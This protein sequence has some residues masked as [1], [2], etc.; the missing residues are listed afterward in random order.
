MIGLVSADQCLGA[1]IPRNL[2]TLRGLTIVASDTK[3]KLHMLHRPSACGCA[4]TQHGILAT[5]VPYHM[6]GKTTNQGNLMSG[7]GGGGVKVGERHGR[8]G[9]KMPE[10]C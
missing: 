1:I 5:H 7:G 3:L 6:L 8:P 4:F 2:G 10:S 9:A